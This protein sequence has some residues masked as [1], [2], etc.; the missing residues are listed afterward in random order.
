M[1]ENQIN[2]ARA[3][4]PYLGIFLAMDFSNRLQE[5][6]RQSPRYRLA[7]VCDFCAR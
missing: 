2:I 6:S 5:T 7:M 3:A 1:T 4:I